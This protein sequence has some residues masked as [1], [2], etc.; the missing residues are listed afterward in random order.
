MNVP[1]PELKVPELNDDE[2]AEAQT[3]CDGGVFQGET[4]RR[5]AAPLP[6]IKLIIS[7]AWRPRDRAQR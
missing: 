1:V 5:L 6:G 4:L 7:G 3:R 2:A